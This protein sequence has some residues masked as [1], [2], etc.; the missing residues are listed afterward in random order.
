MNPR[1]RKMFN[2]LATARKEAALA[3]QAPVLAAAENKEAAPKKAPANKE[4]PLKKAPAKNKTAT[5]SRGFGS[6]K[7]E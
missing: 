6:K 5:K 3:E 7:K 1:R 2:D 4:A